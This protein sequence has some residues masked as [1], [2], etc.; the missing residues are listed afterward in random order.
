MFYIRLCSLF[1]LWTRSFIQ[2]PNILRQL[3]ILCQMW[4][5]TEALLGK[6]NDCQVNLKLENTDK[7]FVTQLG[8]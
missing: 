3:N 2:G 8:C 1:T 4:L 7:Q 6:K 5:I